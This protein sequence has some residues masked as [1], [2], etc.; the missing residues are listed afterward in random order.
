MNTP[1]KV[2][3]NTPARTVCARIVNQW[4]ESGDFPDRMLPAS[5]TERALMQEIV[6]GICR[7]KLLLETII[8]SLV[9]R[10]PDPHT[11]SYLLVGLYQIY[12]MDNIPPH[13]AAN[14]TVEAA[15]ADLDPARVRFINGVL[16]NSL[17]KSEQIQAELMQQ[18]LSIRTSHPEIL[19][20]RW[21]S[22]YGDVAAN[23]ICEWNNLRPD[24][25]LR[26]NTGRITTEAYQEQLQNVGIE[27]RLH[28][29]DPKKRFLILPSG[30]TIKKLPGYREGLF[31]IQDPATLLAVD[32]LQLTTDNLRLLDACAAPGGKTFACA[33]RMNNNGIIIATDR[34]EDRL[35]Q[36]HQNAGRMRYTSVKIHKADAT[37]KLGLSS[38][39]RFGPFDRILLDVPCSNS[40]VLRRRPDARWRF[41]EERLRKLVGIQARMLNACSRLL[42]PDGIM[43]YSTCSLEPEENEQQIERW[44]SLNPGFKIEDQT[45][46]IP[47]ESNMDGA[48]AARLVRK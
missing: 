32:M 6:Y 27:T 41:S 37:R 25:I 46:S 34:H 18:S 48:F 24:V 2:P 13:A 35:A 9:E 38:V 45:A 1:K 14:E 39:E 10:T 30:V 3:I 43:V 5:S 29:A 20:Q 44:V 11:K 21:T 42:A 12:I 26:V 40:G 33:D 7:W 36:L 17:R 28:P 23:E 31:A 19:I 16:R 47:P 8:N 15:K 22:E 4:L